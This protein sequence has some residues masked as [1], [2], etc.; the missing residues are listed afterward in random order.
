MF[1]FGDVENVPGNAE[2]FQELQRKKVIIYFVVLQTD[3]I[4]NF[5][6]LSG[7]CEMQMP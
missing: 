2:F 7:S 5:L 1:N 3:P 4:D 6:Y